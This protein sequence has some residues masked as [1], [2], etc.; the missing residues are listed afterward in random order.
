M[1][2]TL[3]ARR[4]SVP[5]PAVVGGA[6]LLAGLRRQFLAMDILIVV[7]ISILILWCLVAMVAPGARLYP[8]D[9]QFRWAE[10]APSAIALQLAAYLLAYLVFQRFGIAHHRMLHERQARPPRWL[11]VANL[12]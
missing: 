6:P 7:F 5:A 2:S 4:E 12:L 10:M 9:G 1:E 3:S 11:S 8:Y